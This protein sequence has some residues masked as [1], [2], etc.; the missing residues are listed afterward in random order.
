MA[1]KA[2]KKKNLGT[3][4]FV[5]FLV[6]AMTVSVLGSIFYYLFF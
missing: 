3:K 1:Y 4:I 2:R 6:I 5:W